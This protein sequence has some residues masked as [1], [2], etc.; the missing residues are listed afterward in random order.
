[1]NNNSSH[2]CFLIK[3]VVVHLFCPMQS[4]R[5]RLTTSSVGNTS[6]ASTR[7][8][9]VSVA[10]QP[11]TGYGPLSRCH[12]PWRNPPISFTVVQVSVFQKHSLSTLCSFCPPPPRC[13]T[14]SL[15][16]PWSS[17]DTPFWA[18]HL[19]VCT[20]LITM[21]LCLT[22]VSR[23]ACTQLLDRWSP[24]VPRVPKIAR[25]FHLLL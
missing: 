24:S 6:P 5:Y 17:Q 16:A 3:P 4:V 25:L 8:R 11:A 18:I 23:R 1:M 22:R 13:A 20:L 21:Q 12:P 7:L 9:S 14:Q 10:A 2:F 15:P 19:R